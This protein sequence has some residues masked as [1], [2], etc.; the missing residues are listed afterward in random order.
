MRCNFAFNQTKDNT[1]L[2]I[3]FLVYSD[4]INVCDLPKFPDQ[5]FAASKSGVSKINC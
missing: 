4:K 1:K 2:P 3:E 5:H